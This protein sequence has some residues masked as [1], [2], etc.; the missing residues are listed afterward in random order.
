MNNQLDS[1][2]EQ[3]A[4]AGNALRLLGSLGVVTGLAAWFAV[5]R[6]W[7]GLQLDEVRDVLLGSLVVLV[8]RP[9]STR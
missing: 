3:S 1:H 7:P 6:G 4:A 2:E 8:A 5:S 9:W